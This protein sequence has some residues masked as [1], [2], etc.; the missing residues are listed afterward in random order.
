MCGHGVEL[1][2]FQV[3]DFI[4]GFLACL[5]VDDDRVIVRHAH[6]GIELQA[7][8][9]IR[10]HPGYRGP[11]SVVTPLAFERNLTFLI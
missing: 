2:L 4:A 10:A 5:E 6:H 9:D 11:G 1:T 3:F 7:N 8:P